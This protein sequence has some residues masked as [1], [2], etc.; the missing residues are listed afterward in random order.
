MGTCSFCS[1]QHGQSHLCLRD[2]VRENS[3]DLLFDILEWRRSY[4]SFSDD[5]VSLVRLCGYFLMKSNGIHAF[6][7]NLLSLDEAQTFKS[8][9]V[10]AY[11]LYWNGFLASS[12]HFSQGVD[13]PYYPSYRNVKCKL[14]SFYRYR[15]FARTYTYPS[16]RVKFSRVRAAFFW[17]YLQPP[18][19]HCY[20]NGW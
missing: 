1:E 5:L 2:F 12:E 6:L 14:R 17:D 13:H 11:E 10:L 4:L 15:N 7:V 3:V 20:L 18:E 9:S 19:R 16:R 8:I